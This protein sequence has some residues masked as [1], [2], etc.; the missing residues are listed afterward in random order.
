MALREFEDNQD[1]SE[2]NIEENQENETKKDKKNIKLSK[3]TQILQ[4]AGEEL[5]KELENR[6]TIHNNMLIGNL[7][8][9][10]SS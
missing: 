10:V 5:Y 4:K 7:L 1:D 2:N 6:E 8:G 3:H 9:M